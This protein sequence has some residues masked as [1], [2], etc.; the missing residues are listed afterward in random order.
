MDENKVRAGGP[1]K[2]EVKEGNIDKESDVRAS[3]YPN[4]YSDVDEHVPGAF[5]MCASLCP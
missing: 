1:Q 5:V 4:A 3:K 2:Q